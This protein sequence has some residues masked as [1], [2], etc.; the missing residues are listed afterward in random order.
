[1]SAKKLTKKQLKA[2]KK[3]QKAA[4]AHKKASKFTTPKNTWF[5]LAIVLLITTIAF[6]SSINNDFVNWDDDRNFFDNDHITGLNQDNFWENTGKIFTSDVI[7]NYNPLTIWTFLI[8]QKVWGL[9]QPSYWHLDNLL[10]HL[11]CVVFVFFICLRLGIGMWG[12]GLVALLFGVHPMRVESVA[13]VTERKDVLFGIFYLAAIYYYIKNKTEGFKT[14]RLITIL[15]LFVLSLLSKIQAVS[16]PLSLILVDYYFDNKITFKTILSKWYYFALSLA[17]GLLGVYFLSDQGSLEASNNFTAFQRLF[18]GSYSMLVYFIK[19]IVPYEMVPLYP[20][21]DTFPSIFYPTIFVFVGVAALL[22]YSYKKQWKAVF[23]GIGFFVVNVMFL[24][25]ILGAGQGFLADRF[26]YIPYMG[27]F[28]VAGYFFNKYYSKQS[29]LRSKILLGIAIL[30]C[31]LYSF[32]TFQQSKIWKN[33]DT[34]WTHTLKYYD[35]ITLPYGNRANYHRDNG[36]KSAALRDYSAAIALDGKKAAPFNS[37]AKLYF[38]TA[39]NRDTLMM[40]LQDYNKA[41]ELDPTNGEF[42]INR[43]AAYARLGDAQQALVDINKGL[44]LKPDHVSGYINRF[45][46]NSQLGNVDAALNDIETHLKFEKYSA[47]SWYERGRILTIKGRIDEALTDYNKAI[48]YNPNKALFYHERAKV[49]NAL[50]RKQEAI[51]DFRRAEGMGFRVS[52]EL[53]QILGI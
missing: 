13:W 28:F 48:R 20:Y 40:A 51:A 25:Q 50:N 44:E 4:V 43:G 7:G 41:V 26:T 53:R 37:R 10:L 32:L 22:W 11:G 27:L 33:S 52:E 6:S 17:T 45:V 15:V 35:R 8:E 18:V 5:G 36:N 19:A 2:L 42:L 30:G 39:N 29:D 38:T 14:S 46:L 21:S 31:G 3:E 16:L 1:M 47:D 49:F 34:L 12:A 9:D 23:F 24:L